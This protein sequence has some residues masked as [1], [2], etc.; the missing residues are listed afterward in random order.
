MSLL[1]ASAPR[2]GPWTTRLIAS[3]RFQAWAAKFPLT[4]G[5]ARRDGERLFDLVAG[6]VH[7]QVL[8]AVVDLRLIHRLMGGPL[9]AEDLAR[10][11]D[12]PP[13]RMEI[14]CNAATALGLMKRTRRGYVPGRLGAA[15]LGVPG[16]EAMVLHHGA[17][18]RDL[19]NPVAMFGGADTEL[20]RFWPY[21]FG[22]AQAEDPD[23]AAR[24]SD[25][26]AQS[27]VLVAEETLARVDL[28]NAREILDIGGGT[29]AFLQA[30][31]ARHRSPDLHLFDLPAVVPGATA[32]FAQSGLSKRAK[33]TA[34]SFRDD[35]LPQ[36]AEVI[37]LVRVLYDHGDTTVQN[38]LSKAHDSLP[39][40]GRIVVSEPMTGGAKP[41][42]SGDVYF[43]LYCL[44][45]QTGTARSPQKIM[46][47][48]TLAGFSQ[49]TD[50]GTTRPF[51][52]H[53]LSAKRS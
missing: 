42:R 14:L 26:M 18:Y 13:E 27:Q 20:S 43:A 49:V 25:L 31:G 19:E 44:A 34:G 22:A 35:A 51:V 33:I 47:L 28:S 21:V 50:H 2:K 52:T 5:I 29:G 11:T 41:S 32:R 9:S 36:G 53:V 17:F 8:M 4:R 10:G 16:L 30:V 39:R 23:V 48:L 7:S 12:L 46:E 45:M 38:L 1:E 15:M 37:S 24:Y 6:F 3:R 40:G